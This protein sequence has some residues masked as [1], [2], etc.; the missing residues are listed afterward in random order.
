M[1]TAK[2]WPK[3]KN[4]QERRQ[5]VRRDGGG[6]ARAFRRRA[7][8]DP[9]VAPAVDHHRVVQIRAPDASGERTETTAQD[10]IER[11]LVKTCCAALS[12]Y[13]YMLRTSACN[14]CYLCL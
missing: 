6:D 14:S 13:V 8:R 4:G 11:V 12:R 5:R 2:L 1:E 7:R 10:E 9:G 3:T